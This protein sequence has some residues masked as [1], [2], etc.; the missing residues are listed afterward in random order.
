MDW[1][2]GDQARNIAVDRRVKPTFQRLL[3]G[4]GR[5]LEPVVDLPVPEG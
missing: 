3:S 2:I 4:G 1:R 5:L